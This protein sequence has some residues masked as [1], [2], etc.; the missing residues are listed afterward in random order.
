MTGNLERRRRVGRVGRPHG[1]DGAFRVEDPEH[2]LAAATI[3]A[4][5]GQERVVERRAGTAERPVIR[6]RGVGDRDAAHAMRGMELSVSL[7]EAP[8]EAGEWLADDLVGCRIDGVGEVRRVLR[9]PS[10]DLLEAGSA[11]IPFVRD[12][13]RSVDL[14]GR[15]IEVDR[16]FLGLDGGRDDEYP[17]A[18]PSAPPVDADAAPSR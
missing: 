18:E 9:A 14:E 8:L 12:A 13:I 15:H 16:Q 17:Q 11:L 5:G 2:P 7:D 3:V 6:L 1:L 10:C 4:V